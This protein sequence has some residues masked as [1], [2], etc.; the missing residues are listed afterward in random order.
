[1]TVQERKERNIRRR[2]RQA[3][4][5][6]MFILLCTVFMIVLGS[7]IFG[8]TFSDAKNDAGYEKLYKSIEIEKGD[9]LWDIAQEYREPGCSTKEYV[10]E[11]IS[12]NDLSS[13]KI[14]EGQHLIVSYYK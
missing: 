8:S 9:T 13:D 5:R 6:N 11:L 7:I 12:L 1:M 4:K 14:H 3:A 2:R 10:E